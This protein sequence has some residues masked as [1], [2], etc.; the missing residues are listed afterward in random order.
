MSKKKD[1]KNIHEYP[2]RKGYGKTMKRV[3]LKVKQVKK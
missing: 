2:A 1:T 3:L